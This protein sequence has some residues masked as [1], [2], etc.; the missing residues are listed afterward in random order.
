MFM[1]L[2]QKHLDQKEDAPFKGS[3]YRLWLQALVLHLKSKFI[4]ILLF[5][6]RKGTLKI[7]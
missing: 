3:S 2:T 7:S 1:L 6:P 5:L 4:N